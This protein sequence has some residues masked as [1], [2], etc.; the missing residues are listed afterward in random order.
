MN[1]ALEIVLS[2]FLVIGG[3]FGLIGS[4]GLMR[5]KEPMQRLHAP[6]KAT[7]VG[8]GTALI[9]A[10]IATATSMPKEALVSLFLFVTAPISALMLARCHVWRAAKPG[11]LPKDANGVGWAVLKD[12]SPPGRA[13]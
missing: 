7:T 5:L 8:V 9:A 13:D 10:G 11:D 3:L 2:V 1:L 4:F 12:A 6:T